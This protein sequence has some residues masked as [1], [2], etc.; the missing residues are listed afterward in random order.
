[1]KLFLFKLR[2]LIVCYWSDDLPTKFQQRGNLG[3]VGKRR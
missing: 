3:L 1:M 2:G